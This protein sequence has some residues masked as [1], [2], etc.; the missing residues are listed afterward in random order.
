LWGGDATSS[1]HKRSGG[2]H[3]EKKDVSA[4]I[5]QLSAGLIRTIKVGKS[6][7]QFKNGSPRTVGANG[8]ESRWLRGG[9]P[10][11]ICGGRRLGFAQKSP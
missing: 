11:Q 7:G 10:T 3:Q 2:E 8:R 4:E 9:S 6:R 1:G 5:K